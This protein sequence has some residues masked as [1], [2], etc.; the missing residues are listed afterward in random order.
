MYYRQITDSRSRIAAET[1]RGPGLTVT[2]L[3]RMISEVLKA[4]PGTRN[5]TVT[6]EV[7]G[8][9]HYISSGHW[10]FSLKD[11]ESAVSCVMFRQNTLTGAQVRPADGDSVTVSPGPRCVSAAIRFRLSVICL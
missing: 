7:S 3:N 1:Q 8:F 5:V 4:A 11:A 10:Y 6:A 9:K 2:E